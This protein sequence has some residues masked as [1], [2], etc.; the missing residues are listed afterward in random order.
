MSFESLTRTTDEIYMDILAVQQNIKN[1]I[2]KNNSQKVEELNE[3]ERT[4]W[5]ELQSIDQDIYVYLKGLES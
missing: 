2:Q 4:L 5:E 1:Q 3:Q